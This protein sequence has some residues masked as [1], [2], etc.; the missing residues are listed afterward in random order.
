MAA[1][2]VTT[3]SSTASAT[4]ALVERFGRMITMLTSTLP[5]GRPQSIAPQ[6]ELPSGC[7]L[8]PSQPDQAAITAQA[9]RSSDGRWLHADHHL[10]V[11]IARA[12]PKR[13][14]QPTMAF[15]WDLFVFLGLVAVGLVVLNLLARTR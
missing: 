9:S 6:G 10:R 7:K 13:W 15:I 5:I 3:P 4:A 2:T 1:P 12:D 14:W 8:L 11:L